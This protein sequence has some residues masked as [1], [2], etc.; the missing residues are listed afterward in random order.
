[1][2]HQGEVWE[3]TA[4]PG[5][6]GRGF[7]YIPLTVAVYITTPKQTSVKQPCVVFMDTARQEFGQG[8]LGTVG[9][10]SVVPGPQL[11]T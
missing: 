9:S 5:N 11:E 4:C 6:S 2:Y 3:I 8:T 7:M 1:M 10:C